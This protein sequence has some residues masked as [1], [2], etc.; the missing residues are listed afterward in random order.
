MTA[1]ARRRL[2]CV[3]DVG[4]EQID[5]AAGAVRVVQRELAWN[6]AHTITQSSSTPRDRG[7]VQE[8]PRNTVL[9]AAAAARLPAFR[10]WSSRSAPCPSG[11]ST[12][13][14]R[15]RGPNPRSAP[16][17]SPPSPSPSFSRSA[18]RPRSP[19]S[20]TP[21]VAAREGLRDRRRRPHD[22]DHD[23]DRRLQDF[24]RV[25]ATWTLGRTTLQ[26]PRGLAR[27][28]DVLLPPSQPGD[29]RLLFGVRPADL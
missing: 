11:S 6:P 22:V 28:T 24:V 14:A 13:E 25:N 12:S 15:R 8:R 4:V 2:R 27:R 21:L 20:N 9:H 3:R 19:G 29:A 26:P 18:A 1:P 7:Q 23:G 10:S 17:R 16:P 5:D